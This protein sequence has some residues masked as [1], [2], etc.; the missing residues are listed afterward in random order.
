MKNNRKSFLPLIMIISAVIFSLTFYSLRRLFH[1]KELVQKNSIGEEIIIL[2]I[3]LA[4]N[5]SVDW[6][7][8]VQILK[9]FP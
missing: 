9:L 1:L 3:T 7:L 5:I 8:V 4:T 6:F 2:L